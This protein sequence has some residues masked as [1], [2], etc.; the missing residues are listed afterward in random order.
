MFFVVS[1]YGK[2]LDT[3]EFSKVPDFDGAGIV[4]GEEV[5]CVFYDFY[6]EKREHVGSNLEDSIS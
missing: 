2:A 4:H 6:A 1:F 5:G 3:V